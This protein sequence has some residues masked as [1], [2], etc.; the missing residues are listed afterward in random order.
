MTLLPIHKSK[1]QSLCATNCK[2]STP[3]KLQIFRTIF[4]ISCKYLTKNYLHEITHFVLKGNFMQE[5][6][7]NLLGKQEEESM[8][9]DKMSS[10]NGWMVKSNL[11]SNLSSALSPPLENY[12]MLPFIPPVIASFYCISYLP[13]SNKFAEG[14][15]HVILL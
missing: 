5:K 10:I 9:W 8:T 14:L 15:Y 7:Q 11:F 4:G 6:S 3:D 1:P 13:C 12:A 2:S